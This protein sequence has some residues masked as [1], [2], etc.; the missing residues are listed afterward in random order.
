L[1]SQLARG[2]SLSSDTLAPKVMED[3][4]A[5]ATR[6]DGNTVEVEHELVEMNR[7]A[8]EY[9]FLSDVVSR[10]LKQLRMAITGRSA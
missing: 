7:N 4:H 6:P 8:V 2:G 10:D 1:K 9:Q 5:A 3:A